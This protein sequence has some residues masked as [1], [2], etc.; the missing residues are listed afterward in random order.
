MMV[1]LMIS[2]NI[3]LAARSQWERV[4]PDLRRDQSAGD[5]ETPLIT[6]VNGP[7]AL[8]MGDDGAAAWTIV[9]SHVEDEA[10]VSRCDQTGP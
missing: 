8:T 1:A 7:K 3:T 4:P 6:G 10:A 9:A 2:E 5:R